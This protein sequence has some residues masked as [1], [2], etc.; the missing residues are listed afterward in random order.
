MVV[1]SF[2]V[3]TDGAVSEAKVIKSLSEATD[4]EA[5]RVVTSMP[6]WTPGTKNGEVQ[7]MVMNLPIRFALGE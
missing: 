5:L 3:G 4:K 2:T 7:A 6:A 1:V